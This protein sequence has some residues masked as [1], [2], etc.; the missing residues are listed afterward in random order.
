MR[1]KCVEELQR[2]VSEYLPQ[3]SYHGKAYYA[4]YG[5]KE[6]EEE[7]EQRKKK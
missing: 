1:T 2:N 3:K 6:R 7:K 5:E 4:L